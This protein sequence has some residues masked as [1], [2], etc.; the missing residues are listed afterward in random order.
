MATCWGRGLGM[1]VSGGRPETW[2]GEGVGTGARD[3]PP[4]GL[5][6]S[7]PPVV[8]VEGHPP[9]PCAATK[10]Q[11]SVLGTCRYCLERRG[12]QASSGTPAS[13]EGGAQGCLRGRKPGAGLKY[14]DYF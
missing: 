13:R 12:S 2:H 11:P 14:T 7:P 1:T 8:P 9:T 4:L 3:G 5:G 10:P 6:S